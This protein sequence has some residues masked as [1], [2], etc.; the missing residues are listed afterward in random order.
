MVSLGFLVYYQEDASGSMILRVS[1]RNIFPTL[2]VWCILTAFILCPPHRD[3]SMFLRALSRNIFP[4]LASGLPPSPNVHGGAEFTANGKN[5]ISDF[6]SF[7][8][9]WIGTCKMKNLVLWES[10]RRIYWKKNVLTY[11][12]IRE[13]GWNGRYFWKRKVGPKR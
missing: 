13:N 10:H 2:V 5:T 12:W 9:L 1:G 7:D 4:F 8:F 6:L 3:F 11:F